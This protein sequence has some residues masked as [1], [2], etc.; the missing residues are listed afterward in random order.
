[1]QKTFLFLAAIIGGLGVIIGAFGAHG[2]KDLIDEESLRT[3]ETGVRFQFYHVFALI[4][5]SLLYAAKP[6]KIIRVSCWLCF[7]GII[8]F[9]GSIYLLAT[10]SLTGIPTSILGPITPL[11]GLLVL[12]AWVLM[13]IYALMRPFGKN[14][15]LGI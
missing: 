7:F 4:A 9:S 2:L 14:N 12:A 1:M 8:A 5:C 13:S 6:S 3:Y 11:G 15:L 10:S